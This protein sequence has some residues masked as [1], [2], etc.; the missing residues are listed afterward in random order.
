MIR[1][2]FAVSLAAAVATPAFAHVTLDTKEAKVGASFK[3]VLRVPHGCGGTATTALR[4]RIPEGVIAVK[5]MPKPG[6]TLATV[7]GAYAKSYNQAHGTT[8]AK[9]VREIA[10]TGGN[11][12]D[13]WYD[14][15]VFVGV[16]AADMKA[17]DTLYFPVVQE[18][19]QGVHRW[20]GIPAAGATATEDA[21]PAPALKLVPSTRAP[22]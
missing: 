12:P 22:H 18:C 10:W 20:I 6:W 9:G 14:E 13:K 11:L 17:G 4:V 16:V 15:F 1:W 2:F 21:E 8:L 19:E 5:P 7:D 3:G